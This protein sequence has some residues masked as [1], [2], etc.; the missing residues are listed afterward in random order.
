MCM[1]YQGLYHKSS[2]AMIH[3]ICVFLHVSEND[4]YV[5]ELA[6]IS[7]RAPLL[8][9]PWRMPNTVGALYIR[10]VRLLPLFEED[11]AIM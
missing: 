4:S 6:R 3:T 7:G 8:K 11:T 2:T 10:D 5:G 1:Y 9:N